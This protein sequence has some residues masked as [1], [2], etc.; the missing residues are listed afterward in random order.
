MTNYKP[1]S[2]KLVG[3]ESDNTPV[4]LNLNN[5]LIA[6]AGYDALQSP[7]GTDYAVPSGK[8]LRIFSIGQ[9]TSAGGN[10]KLG[11]SDDAA[12]TN[13]VTLW[14]ALSWT[15]LTSTWE[16]HYPV[17]FEIPATKYV[18]LEAV[19]AVTVRCIA[20]GVEVDA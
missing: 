2:L 12:G 3:I 11:Y 17:H 8:K 19:A 9:F 20:F 16:T 10:L 18:T 5:I 4:A 1:Q 7:I 14:D 13:A 15:S 6:A